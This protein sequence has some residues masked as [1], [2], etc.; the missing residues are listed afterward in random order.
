MRKGLSN[1]ERFHQQARGFAASFSGFFSSLMSLPVV[2]RS[3]AKPYRQE[4]SFN[5]RMSIAKTLLS[6]YPDRIPVIV[7]R[8][9]GSTLKQIDKRK[10]LVPAG[11]TTA[12]FVFVVKKR[13]DLESHESLKLFADKHSLSTPSELMSEVYR[14][15]KDPDGFLYL[16]YRGD[17]SFGSQL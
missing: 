16:Q 8:A 11:M 14:N 10:F 13:I 15:F 12:N 9:E 6:S 5:D 7:E 17:S 1:P 2:E 4:K 3:S